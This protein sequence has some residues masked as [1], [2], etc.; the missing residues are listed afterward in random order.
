MNEEAAFIAALVKEPSDKT[1]ALVF[2]DWLDERGDPRGPMMRIDEVRTWMAPKY[3]NPLPQLLAAMESGKR[4]MEASKILALLGETAVPGLVALL[5]HKLPL[6]RTRT[7]KVLRMM[8][9]RGKIAVPALIALIKD[10]DGGVRNEAARAAKAIGLVGM[11]DT[12]VLSEALHDKDASVR[13]HAASLLGSM[14]A[15]RAVKDVLAKGLDNKDA[16]QRLAAIK[17]MATLHTR[18]AAGALCKAL[19]DPELQVRRDAINQLD[20]LATPTMTVAVEPLCKVLGDTDEYMRAQAAHILGKIGP[21]AAAAL[22]ELIRRMKAADS[23]ERA[24]VVEAIALIG[25]GRQEVWDVILSALRDPSTEVQ[26]RAASTLPAWNP[27]PA[28]AAPVILEF[29]RTPQTVVQHTTHGPKTVTQISQHNTRYCLLALSRLTPLP[30]EVVAEFWTRLAHKDDYTTPMVV[31][32][33]GERASVLLPKLISA[34]HPNAGWGVADIAKALAKIGGEGIATLARALDHPPVEGRNPY[35]FNITAATGL[36]EAGPAA[37]PLLTELLARVR[38]PIDPSVGAQVVRVIAAMGPGAASAIPDLMALLTDD[39]HQ[40]ESAVVISALRAFGPAVVPYVPQL[41]AL[42]KQPP[43]SP[44]SHENITTLLT[45]LI[46]HGVDVLNVFRE[47]LRGAIAG[48]MYQGDFHRSMYVARAAIYGLATLG[49]GAAAAMPD[50]ALAFQT[51]NT[52]GRGDVRTYVLTTYGKIGAAAL[53]Q[54]HA[55]LCDSSLHIRLA[56][57]DALNTTGDSSQDT[58]DAIRTAETDSAIKVRKRA[59]KLSK[60]L[61]AMKEKNKN[62]EKKGK[63]A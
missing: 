25:P 51:F 45:N 27:I 6:V 8:G 5:S 33:M 18:T 23:K 34:F 2:A 44:E 50:L 56:A 57:L 26:D 1:A 4:I 38:K 36:Q 53:P 10:A 59:L 12:T 31:A 37:L 14:R 43:R 63:K 46:P 11:K 42:L 60:K 30:P 7:V 13:Y 29:M 61:A 48:D 54:I 24:R 47:V 21:P 49:P 41:V 52:Y 28:S 22:D 17:A 19:A 32:R 35:T 58:L 40:I 15:K 62:K 20:R 9:P 55:A 16:N 3:A 39:K